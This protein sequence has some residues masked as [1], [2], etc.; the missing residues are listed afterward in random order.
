[1]T[2]R[3][4]SFR[5]RL[6]VAGSPPPD[7]ETGSLA[8][9]PIIRLQLLPTPPRGDA[10]TFSYRVLAYSDTDFHRADKA[11][12][13]A[14]IPTPWVYGHAGC[15]PIPATGA[16][17]GGQGGPPGPGLIIRY[18]QRAFSISGWTTLG[19]PG[20]LYFSNALSYLVNL[21]DGFLL[22]YS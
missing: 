6:R 7:A 19:P 1:M 15:Q 5:L 3:R 11:P 16:K 12:S 21:L 14:H 10:V 22:Q 18:L 17:K 13:R 20:P 2:T 4:V 9:G 8:Y